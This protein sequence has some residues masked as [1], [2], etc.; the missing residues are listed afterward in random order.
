MTA[1]ISISGKALQKLSKQ[2]VIAIEQKILGGT[3]ATALTSAVKPI[4]A[5]AISNAIGGKSQTGSTI[6]SRAFQPLA[7]PN[8]K[9]LVGRLGVGKAGSVSTDKLKNAWRLLLPSV[10]L[11]GEKTVSSLSGTFS[12][13]A[14]RGGRFGT[15]NFKI[16]VEAFYAARI[17]TYSYFKDNEFVLIPWMKHYIEGVEIRNYEFVKPGSKT[18]QKA[19]KKKKFASI[20]RTGLGYLTK[21]PSGQM[22]IAPASAEPFVLLETRVLAAF[23]TK[24]FA[25]KIKKAISETTG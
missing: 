2:V 11:T 7:Q 14:I 8:A 17:S 22:S 10:G 19:K 4:V 13:K 3:N 16:D 1:K 18:F 15:F 12:K 9:D 21:V 23:R 20:S 5:E 6:V 25:D 24:E